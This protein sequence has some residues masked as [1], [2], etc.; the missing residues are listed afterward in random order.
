MHIIGNRNNI[1][2][3]LLRPSGTC[4]DVGVWFY[5]CVIPPGSMLRHGELLRRIWI[6]LYMYIIGHRNNIHVGLLRHSGTCI[7]TGE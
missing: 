7:R 3:G 2:V 6:I 4:I 1:H 5:R